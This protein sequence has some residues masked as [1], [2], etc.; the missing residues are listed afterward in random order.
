M[1]FCVRAS[2][3][4]PSTVPQNIL[5]LKR[6]EEDQQEAID[7]YSNYESLASSSSLSTLVP[8][9]PRKKARAEAEDTAAAQLRQDESGDVTEYDHGKKFVSDD[10][11]FVK[12]L[13]RENK[14]K[15][16]AVAMMVAQSKIPNEEKAYNE[17]ACYDGST[18]TMESWDDEE[19]KERLSGPIDDATYEDKATDKEEFT[20]YT[21]ECAV[22][23]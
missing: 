11:E 17:Y 18:V 4:T 16:T 22:T 20:N 12:A 1:I 19:C 5:K 15:A 7:C 3:P 2:P 10:D 13:A 6:K 21:Y 14:T 8:H 9:S 23:Y